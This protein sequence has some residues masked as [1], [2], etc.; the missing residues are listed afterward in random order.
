MPGMLTFNPPAASQ[1]EKVTIT[2]G[3]QGVSDFGRIAVWGYAAASDKKPTG[4]TGP[5]WLFPS[6]CMK[7]MR[8]HSSGHEKAA[9]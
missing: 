9:R 2:P 1:G 6:R 4:Q 8:P 3:V 5:M 7:S